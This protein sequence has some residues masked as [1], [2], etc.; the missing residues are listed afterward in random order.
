MFFLDSTFALHLDECDRGGRGKSSRS[1]QCVSAR[2]VS[3]IC[4][5]LIGVRGGKGQGTKYLP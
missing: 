2:R 5:S 3:E 1:H 4:G